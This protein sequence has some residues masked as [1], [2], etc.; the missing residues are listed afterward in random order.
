[1]SDA[2]SA[3]ARRGAALAEGSEAPATAAEPGAPA[4]AGEGR[5]ERL[6]PA[7]RRVR[8]HLRERI[9]DRTATVLA[10]MSGGVDSSVTAALLARAGHRVTGATIKTF[11]YSEVDGPENTCCGLEGIADAKAVAGRVGFP[12]FVYDA[13]AAFAR[14]VIDDFVSE[15]AAGRT[16]IP[17]VRCNSF[18]K[19]R[20]LL[21]RADALGCD[22]MATGHYARVRRGD[23]GETRILRAEDDD[24]DQT[25]FLWAIPPEA[26]ERLVLPVGE[27]RKD[28]VRRVARELEL[29]TADKPESFEICFVPDNDYRGVL[30]R[31]LGEDHPA[32]SPGPFLL[33]GGEEVG[34]HE[35]YADFTVGQRKGLPGGFPEPMYVVEIRPEDRAVVIGPRGSLRTS[36]VEAGRP[37]WLARPPEPG[38]RVGVRVRHGAPVVE[39]EVE[40]VSG[41]GFALETAVDQRA[42]TPGQSAVVYRDR[43]LV[44]GGVIV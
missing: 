34:R 25:Y 41:E 1:M 36:R 31:Y 27:V 4:S 16:P 26:V 15:Y 21:R 7:E 20:D 33:E 32:L 40:E 37:N 10:A 24:K 29:S 13:E 39:A 18:T 38:E 22:F 44:G 12:H 3:R 9:G 35:G 30:R 43:V 28:E 11:C 14:D 5:G 19:F 17:C 6:P 2:A 23:D 8:R 42:V